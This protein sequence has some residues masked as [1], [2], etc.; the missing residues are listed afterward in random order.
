MPIYKYPLSG[1]QTGYFYRD[2][3]FKGPGGLTNKLENLN[4]KDMTF[5]GKKT[6]VL[7][8]LHVVFLASDAIHLA[9][10]DLYHFCVD[11]LAVLPI[12][13]A[14][15][16]KIRIFVHGDVTLNMKIKISYKFLVPLYLLN[17]WAI[18][19]KAYMIILHLRRED[20]DYLSRLEEDPLSS[21]LRI[22]REDWITL[23]ART[24]S[25]NLWPWLSSGRLK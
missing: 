2:H 21:E 16:L 13:P 14:G 18:R 9:S 6:Y 12:W 22:C 5:L 15:G 8:A 23:N 11:G 17:S 3:C 1:W 24:S 19:S 4:I 20:I 25:E 7:L 10:F